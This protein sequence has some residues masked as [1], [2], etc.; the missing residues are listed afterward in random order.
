MRFCINC[1]EALNSNHYRI[2]YCS[3]ACHLAS[4]LILKPSGCMEC[5]SVNSEGYGY[6]KIRSR[7]FVSI[8]AHRLS[9]ELSLGTIPDGMKVC[10]TCDNKPCAVPHHL[11]LGTDADNRA[12]SVKKGRHA[13]GSRSG[14]SQ[15]TEEVATAIYIDERKKAEIARAYGISFDIVRCIKNGRAWGWLTGEHHSD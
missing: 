11:F 14:K 5:S 9:Y 4:K 13:R 15:I 10:H 7:G 8:L 12:D 6:L 2:K 1:G 3:D